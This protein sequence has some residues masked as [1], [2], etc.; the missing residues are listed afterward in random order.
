M[1]WKLTKEELDGMD[2]RNVLLVVLEDQLRF[3]RGE[4]LV[5][6]GLPDGAL[7]SDVVVAAITAFYKKG[8]TVSLFAADC[9]GHLYPVEIMGVIVANPVSM[10]STEQPLLDASEG[11]VVK[12]PD[13][14]MVARFLCAHLDALGADGFKLQY[15]SK[16]RCYQ[17][18]VLNP[19]EPEAVTDETPTITQ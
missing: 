3:F 9:M 11:E 7:L 18:E 8:A 2:P 16:G 4:A 6:P 15:E 12:V 17:Y 1:I 19:K 10:V 13:L 14:E 5:T